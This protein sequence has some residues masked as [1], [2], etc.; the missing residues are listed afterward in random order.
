M[1]SV[2]SQIL[3]GKL[4]GHIVWR[5]QHSFALM[6]IRPLR[7]GHVLVM[8]REEFDH[9]DDLPAALVGEL[10]VASQHIAK[11]IKRAFPCARVGLAICGL[12]I[13]HAHIHLF[14]IDR[15]ED[16]NFGTGDF[17]SAA[18]LAA[19]AACIR[20]ELTALGFAAQASV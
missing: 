17:A 1:A 19:A 11:A 10:M 20:T 2:F 6:T 16:F 8:P 14:P 18:D 13:P 15:L 9:W 7:P 5:D 12:E 3:D 4:P